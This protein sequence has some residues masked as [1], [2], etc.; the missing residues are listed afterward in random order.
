MY[1]I[2]YDFSRGRLHPGTRRRVAMV[3]K[4]TAN[5]GYFGPTG[6]SAAGGSSRQVYSPVYERAEAPTLAEEFLPTDTQTQNRIFRNL[7]TFDPIAGPAI[8]Y[9]KDMAF[10]DEIYVGNVK[11]KKVQQLYEDAIDASGIVQELPKLLAD[12]L[13]FGRFIFHQT[14]DESKGYWTETIPHDPDYVEIIVSP[15][16]SKPPIVN[17][18]PTNEHQLW[19]TS[20]DPRIIEQRQ[21]VDPILLQ[22]MASGQP[23]PLAWENT[24]FMGRSVLSGDDYGTSILSRIIPFKIYEKALL[25]ASINA[26]RRRAGP[27]WIATV[28]ADYSAEEIQEVI[29]NL[30]ASEE[31]PVGGKV[32]V[33]EGV[34]ITPMGGG[35]GDYWKISDEQDFLRAGK[36]NAMGINDAFITGEATYNSMETVLSVFLEKLRAVRRLFTKRIIM[37]KMLRTLALEHGC[38]QRTK[39]EL[40]HRVRF[41]HSIY[42][43]RRKRDITDADLIL[44]TLEWD[45]PLEPFADRD[46]WDM[47]QQLEE[48]GIIIPLRKWSQ[49]AGYDLKESLDNTEAD[50]HDRKDMLAYKKAVY[51][52]AEESGFD[53][54]GNF[55]GEEAGGEEGGM[56]EFEFG[57]GEEE[58]T[59]G[60]EGFEFEEEYETA[61]PAEPAA[62]ESPAASEEGAGA[63]LDGARFPVDVPPTQTRYGHPTAAE[64]NLEHRLGY[65]PLWDEADT[66]FSVPRRRVAHH[67]DQIRRSD[68]QLRDA[69]NIYK[70]LRKEGM[71]TLQADAVLYCATRLGHLRRPQLDSESI[72]VLQK[73]I[74]DRANGRFSRKITRE[75]EA[76]TRIARAG[77]KPTMSRTGFAKILSKDT[78]P[79]DKLLTGLTK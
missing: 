30:M 49:A 2:R 43:A 5:S 45:Q 67:L 78:L 48:K 50:I 56:G 66:I 77:R 25:D 73:Y 22:H 13:T 47:L 51:A 70:L 65:L 4:R 38:V 12:Y 53:M 58:E 19:A 36:L 41:G 7:I 69:R 18:Q 54:E 55:I 16:P 72:A 34:T 21:D 71:N 61:P 62:P 10:G 20:Q 14:M 42:S 74:T 1:K 52:Q 9:Y 75:L 46:Y 76:L 44:P 40:A 60:E 64:V 3:G 27:V 8:E 17:L 28:P 29:D 31:D 23:I 26:S 24:M 63:S 68:P 32:A 79:H 15:F 59:E 35:P 33:R 11:D 39:A 37:D 6:M 57:G